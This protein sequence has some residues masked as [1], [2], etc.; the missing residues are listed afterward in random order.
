MRPNL[1]A[2]KS[3]IGCLVSQGPKRV[4]KKKYPVDENGRRFSNTYFNRTLPNGESVQRRRLLYS[5]SKD[6]VFCFCCASFK[7]FSQS[8]LAK[9]GSNDWSHLSTALKSHECSSDQS[10]SYITWIDAESRIK[11]CT[12]IDKAEQLSM[13]RECER[14]KNVLTTLMHITLY[15]AENNMAFR[16]SSDKLYT[17]KNGEYLG[18]IQLFAKFDPVMQEHFDFILR[19]DKTR[20]HYCGKKT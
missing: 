4:Q 2:R 11:S 6:L 19:N 3:Q 17:P 9:V 18:L 15:L 16:G 12:T 5:E 10:A 14:W 1:L 20:V 7:P 13:L 8:R